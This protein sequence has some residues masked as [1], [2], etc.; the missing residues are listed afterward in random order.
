[1]SNDRKVERRNAAQK[2]KIA[3]TVTIDSEPEL[4]YTP[5]E[6]I[7]AIVERLSSTFRKDRKS[8]SLQFRL[9]Q[10][11]NIHYAMADNFDAISDALYK[12]FQRAPLETATLE[13]GPLMNELVHTMSHLKKWMEPEP[14]S[15]L[16]SNMRTTPVYVERIPLGTVLIISPFNYPLLLT[17]SSLVAAISGGNCV[18]LKVSELVPNFARVLTKILTEALDPDVFAMVNGAIPETTELLNQKFDK[19]MYTGS[20]QVGTLIAKKAAETLTPVL[21]ELGGKSPAFVLETMADKDIEVVARRIAWGRFVNAGQTCVAIDYV[22]VHESVKSK[23]VNALSKV[24]QDEFYNKIDKNNSNFSHI[25]N[26]RAFKRIRTMLNASRGSIIVG[27]EFDEETRYIS[28]TLLN[29][30]TWDDSSMQD[31]I[32]GPVLPIIGYTNLEEAVNEVAKRHD[33]PLA[34]YIF[35]SSSRLR[36]KC[37]Q[38]DL[39]R[40]AIRSGG[41][42]INDSVL[43]V[44]LANAPFGG[45]GPSGQGNYHGKYSFRAFT[46]ERTVIEQSLKSDFLLKVR[47][48]PVD[49]KKM[50]VIMASSLPYNKKVWFG[51]TGDVPTGGPGIAWAFW[52]SIAGAASLIAHFSKSL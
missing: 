5:L 4:V 24:I 16:P 26:E 19:I 32:F 13:Y 49:E 6:K 31:E 36:S 38:V 25:V 20:T 23:L 51:R 41:H 39:I 40:T 28:P 3:S 18:V 48:P 37:P 33:M 29:D 10:L 8:H 7:P 22:L 2:P 1:M 44:A 27:G 14:V 43:H 45:I 11:R 9:N 42:I 15:D 35:T 34:L 52:N 30:V 12:D 47:Y 50:N 21:L 17:V 46:H